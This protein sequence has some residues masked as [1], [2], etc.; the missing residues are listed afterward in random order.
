MTEPAFSY[1]SVPPLYLLVIPT[2]VRA[3]YPCDSAI[4][5]LPELL[6][7]IG[8]KRS[9]YLEHISEQHTLL[10][11]DQIYIFVEQMIT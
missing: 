9:Q 2:E 1:D 11:P 7:T 8:Q 3:S 6:M 10:R 4:I 5:S